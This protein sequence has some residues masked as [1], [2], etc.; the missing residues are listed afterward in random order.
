MQRIFAIGV[1]VV[2]LVGCVSAR[3]QDLVDSTATRYSGVI[4]R[5]E[6]GEALN[7]AWLYARSAQGN[8]RYETQIGLAIR[9]DAPVVAFDTL[10]VLPESGVPQ[11]FVDLVMQRNLQDRHMPGGEGA[12]WVIRVEVTDRDRDPLKTVPAHGAVS[13]E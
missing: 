7:S 5:P 13:N 1:A 8:G 2:F 3:Y 9:S 11:T 10:E 6:K 12:Q 4:W